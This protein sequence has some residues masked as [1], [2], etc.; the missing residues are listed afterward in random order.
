[1]KLPVILAILFTGMPLNAEVSSDR[2]VMSVLSKAGCNQ[3]TCHGNQNGKGGFKLSLRGQDAAFDFES[4][5]RGSSSRRVNLSEPSHS[6]NLLKSTMKIPRQGR[7][8]A[9]IG[10]VY[11]GIADDRRCG[12]QR[13]GGRDRDIVPRSGIQQT[14]NLGC[15]AEQLTHERSQ[16]KRI[17]SAIVELYFKTLSRSPS[18]PEL[19]HAVRLLSQSKD[20]RRTLEDIAWALMNST[21]FLFRP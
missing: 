19:D 12:T 16:P 8:G 14:G 9:W 3:G 15:V 2:D 6:L 13:G 17:Q 5:T 20:Q 1:M 11:F 4:L 18:P 21:E 10:V 7:A